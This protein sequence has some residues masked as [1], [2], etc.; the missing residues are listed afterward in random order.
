LII[1]FVKEFYDTQ[2]LPPRSW[3]LP[4]QVFRGLAYVAFTIWLIRS[5]L[6]SRW[7]VGLSMALLFPVYAGV[8]ALL[9]PN[10][11]MP[12]HVRY[13]HMLEIGWSNFVFGGLVGFLFWQP[14][15]SN[16]AHTSNDTE[17]RKRRPLHEQSTSC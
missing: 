8:A 4:L 3:I 17:G 15:K 9:V 10:A 12:D 1:G 14:I 7:Q 13:W 6:G 5:M 2:E 16:E 11:I